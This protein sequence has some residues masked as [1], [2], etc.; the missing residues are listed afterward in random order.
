MTKLNM[1]ILKGANYYR[2]QS[3][4]RGPLKKQH[5]QSTASYTEI[6]VAESQRFRSLVR[7]TN[8]RQTVITSVGDIDQC[9]G[10]FTF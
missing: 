2:E 4:S 3:S 5:A 9:P 1:F 8:I 7:H 10:P 6:V